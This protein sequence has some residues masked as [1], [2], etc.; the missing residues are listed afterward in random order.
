MLVCASRREGDIP[1]INVQNI[2]VRLRKKSSLQALVHSVRLSPAIPANTQSL[3]LL[4][5]QGCVHTA[6]Q[7]MVLLTAYTRSCL[8][9]RRKTTPGVCRK[10]GAQA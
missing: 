2:S 10:G 6:V 3:H 8:R 1:E 7:A 9:E 5:L 4:F